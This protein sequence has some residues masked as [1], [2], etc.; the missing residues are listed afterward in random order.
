MADDGA[1]RLCGARTRSGGQ[2]RQPAMVGQARC[3]MHGGLSPQALRAAAERQARA[4]ALRTLRDLG[5]VEPV[6]DPV[7]ALEHLA[8]Q[9]VA[10][11]EVLRGLVSKLEE[12]RYSGGPGSGGE[13][14][15]GELTAYLS[16]LGRAESI[17]GRIVALDLD[18]RRVRLQEAQAALVVAAFARVLRHRELAL[19]PELQRR[20][21][22]LLAAELGQ[23]VGT[24]Q[25]L[26]PVL[27]T[28]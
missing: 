12:V 7:G 20:A 5:E 1:R 22:S 24:D 3:R 28:P 18:A 2:C 10:L 15:R 14:L 21:R 16:A 27:V 23:P 9:A 4:A 8:G 19:A 26:P 25:E 17:L 11:V 6:T 13:Q